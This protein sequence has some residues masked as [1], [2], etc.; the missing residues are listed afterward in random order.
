[1]TSDAK[2]E[3]GTPNPNIS[4]RRRS[5]PRNVII[6]PDAA[7]KKKKTRDNTQK[8]SEEATPMHIDRDG[9]DV[10]HHG[11]DPSY[12]SRPAARTN[13]QSTYACFGSPVSMTTMFYDQHMIP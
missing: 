1:V 8:S 11:V 10:F 4:N 12:T 9:D 6:Q 13:P 2:T 7:N 5:T 3:V